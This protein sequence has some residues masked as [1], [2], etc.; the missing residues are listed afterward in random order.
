MFVEHVIEKI[1]PTRINFIEFCRKNESLLFGEFITKS[2][3][4]SPYFFNFGNFSVGGA[5]ETLGMYYAQKI[6]LMKNK[7]DVIFGSAYKGISLVVATSI[8]LHRLGLVVGFCYNRKEAKNHG[9]Q[10]LLIGSSIN[11]KQVL[12]ID[13]VISSGGSIIESS[14]FIKGAGGNVIGAVVAVD[15]EERKGTSMIASEELQTKHNINVESLIN[16]NDIIEYTKTVPE[17]SQY[18]EQII[19]YSRDG[20]ISK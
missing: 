8:A 2:G 6:L 19:N 3:R 5:V 1:Y 15:R 14:K 20:S 12:I 7:P 11:N 13:D 16:L 4:K 9:E 18:S 17:L 10:G